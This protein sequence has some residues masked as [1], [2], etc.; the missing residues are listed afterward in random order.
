MINT[1]IVSKDQTLA[2]RARVLALFLG[3]TTGMAA[4]AADWLQ[5]RGPNGSGIAAADARPATK[6][7]ETSNL[8]WKVALPGHGSSSP[9]VS[10]ERV[11]ITGYSGY[12]D[13]G[14]GDSPAK[15]Q[16]HLVC[17]QRNT[18]KV[19]WDKSTRLPAAPQFA[20]VAQNKLAG[21]DSDFNGTPA[22]VGHQLFLR[23]NRFLYC[24]E[25]GASG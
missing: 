2:C 7:S 15:L 8:K 20:L 13:G 19:H 16:R 5:F 6:W 18:G 23:S 3:V 1:D 12:G 9:I 17:L 25:A 22:I 10:G 11:F 21:D 24:I 14:S 4:A